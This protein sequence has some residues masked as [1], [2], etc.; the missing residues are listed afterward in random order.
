MAVKR[1]INQNASNGNLS[2]FTNY[3]EVK[4]LPSKELKPSQPESDDS[5]RQSD[6][7]ER[8]SGSDISASSRKKMGKKVQRQ[9]VRQKSQWL[10]KSPYWLKRM[11]AKEDNYGRTRTVQRKPALRIIRTPPRLFSL[12]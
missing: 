8:G 1:N 9:D 11:E 7:S 10:R 4:S 5:S 2:A 3:N 6:V 12:E